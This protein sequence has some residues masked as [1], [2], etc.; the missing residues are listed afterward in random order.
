[1]TKPEFKTFR[2]LMEMEFPEDK[3]V[4]RLERPNVIRFTLD[5]FEID[6]PLAEIRDEGDLLSWIDYLGGKQDMTL[7]A[8]VRFIRLAADAKQFDLFR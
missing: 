6:V 4:R 5:D 7:P 8:L 1:M 3:Q 2:E